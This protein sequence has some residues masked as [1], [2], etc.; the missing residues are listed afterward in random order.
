MRKE[1]DSAGVATTRNTL[2]NKPITSILLSLFALAVATRARADDVDT[3][4][5]ASE[6]GQELRDQAKLT[7]ARELFVQC[8]AERCPKIV[9][10]DCAE[11]L[12]AVN[13]AIPSVTL[14]ARH[15]DGRDLTD[16][17]VTLDDKPFADRLDGRALPL[18][19]GS[20]TLRFR[21]EG[22]P[23][24]TKTLLLHEG[25]KGR[26]VD[27]LFG[28]PEKPDKPAL[29]IPVTSLVLGGVSL[30]SF[31][32]MAGLGWSAKSAVDDMRATC[33]GHCDPTRVEAARRD[34]IL[35]NVA[36]GVGVASLGAAVVIAIAARPSPPKTTAIPL[37]SKPFEIRASAAGVTFSG[38]F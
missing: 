8:A 38:S 36:L 27:V 9:R 32:A 6:K 15:A 18:D 13:E 5:T 10:K 34:M 14:R 3:C 17:R 11:W 1:A 31:G 2:K 4:A 29:P 24:I 26:A 28:S 37:V 33:E 25:E 23:E 21:A 19:P 12:A 20:H 16:V 30:A 35:A 7:A 22:A